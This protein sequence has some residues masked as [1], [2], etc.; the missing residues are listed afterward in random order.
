[1]IGDKNAACRV[2]QGGPAKQ[3]KLPEKHRRTFELH[4]QKTAVKLEMPQFIQNNEGKCIAQKRVFELRRASA[5][6]TFADYFRDQQDKN[7]SLQMQQSTQ[8]DEDQ[9]APVPGKK[10]AVHGR[11]HLGKNPG[12]MLFFFDKHIDASFICRIFCYGSE[13]LQMFSFAGF[14]DLKTLQRSDQ[15]SFQFFGNIDGL[16]DNNIWA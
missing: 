15:R 4:A 11:Y 12:M 16:R 2:K 3:N 13:L 10:S 7:F 1:M 5:V 14:T 8:A 9:I 6:K